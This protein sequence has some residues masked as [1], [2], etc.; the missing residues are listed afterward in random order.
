MNTQV[1]TDA[2]GMYKCL[3]IVSIYFSGAQFC[4]KMLINQCERDSVLLVGQILF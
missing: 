1:I 3:A 4:W 2:L